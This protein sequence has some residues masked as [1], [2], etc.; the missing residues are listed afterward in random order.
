MHESPDNCLRVLYL[1]QDLLFPSRVTTVAK[2]MGVDVSIVGSLEQLRE[3]LAVPTAAVIV[4]LEHRAAVPA[5]IIQMLKDVSPRPQVIGYG[6][7]VKE[8]LLAA[9]QTAG[10]DQVLSRGQFDKQIG[11]LVQ[12]WIPTQ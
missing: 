12:S 3:R 10:F 2:Q 8:A 4:D 7:H 11:P 6:P 1:T 9:A 5:E